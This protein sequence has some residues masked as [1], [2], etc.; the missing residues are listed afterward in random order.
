MKTIHTSHQ[1]ESDWGKA[2]YIYESKEL[3]A[4]EKRPFASSISRDYSTW[5]C[6]W[7][8]EWGIYWLQYTESWLVARDEHQVAA[9][10]AGWYIGCYLATPSIVIMWSIAFIP[11]LLFNAFLELVWIYYFF[12]QEPF[13]GWNEKNICFSF[14]KKCKKEKNCQ[15][16]S[17]LIRYSSTGNMELR[18]SLFVGILQY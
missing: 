1:E 16:L 13:K 10:A 4:N 11:V 2:I 3:N 6:W 18:L 17:S 8:K 5:L 12:L 9:A 7:K 14:E 15:R